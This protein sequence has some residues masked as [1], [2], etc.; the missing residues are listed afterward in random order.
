M[1]KFSLK[2]SV[3]IDSKT[4]VELWEISLPDNSDCVAN[5]FYRQSFSPDER[6][7]VF[8]SNRTGTFELYRM[9]TNGD[10]VVQLTEGFGKIYFWTVFENE[11]ICNDGEKIFA[12]DIFDLKE[13]VICQKKENFTEISG[14]PLISGDGEKIVCLC[15]SEK[16]WHIGCCDKEGSQLEEIYLFPSNF[17][18]ISHLQTAPTQSLILT[19]APLPDFQNKT[20]LPP[21]KRARAWKIDLEKHLIEPF[22]VMPE[23]FR[24]THEYW[25]NKENI[26]L[27]FHKKTVPSFTPATIAS[28]NLDGN[29]YKEHFFSETRKLGHSFISPDNSLMVSDVQ[30]PENNELYLI[31]L[32]TGNSKIV[33]WPDSSCSPQRNQLGHVHPSFSSKGNYIIYSSDKNG[34]TNVYIVPLKQLK[35]ELKK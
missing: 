24:A 5:Y 29:D 1:E 9:E 4:N 20:G 18:T 26:R 6:Y 34:K 17:E 25:G 11:I 12:I 7:L 35:K 22:L 32:K 3:L 15:K 28:I 8:S 27:Y 10:E 16:A 33:C 14:S 13:R 30:E 21:E 19:F 31:D 23:G 2:K